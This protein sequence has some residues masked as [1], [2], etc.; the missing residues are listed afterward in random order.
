MKHAIIILA[1]KEFDHLFHLIEYFSRDCSVFVHIDRRA[2]ITKEEIEHIQSLSQVVGV[3]R[4]YKVHWGGFSILKCE[5]FMLREVLQH[6]DA[7]FVHLLSGQDYPVKPLSEFLSYFEAHPDENFI[8][9]IPLP[10]PRWEQYTYSRFQYFYPYDWVDDG[11]K[12]RKWVYKWV[13]FQKRHHIKRRIPDV[14]DRMYGNS[15]WFSITRVATEALVNYTRKHPA[16][17][18]R[19]RMTFAPE[20]SYIA[21]VL[22]N[23][24]PKARFSRWN[25]WFI[26]WR[27]QNGNN[28]ANLDTTHFHF[29]LERFYLFARKFEHPYGDGL[30]RLI[31]QY[32]I[33][34]EDPLVLLPTGGWKYDGMRRYHYDLDFSNALAEACRALSVTRMLDMGCGNGLYVANLRCHGINAAGY[35]ANPYTEKL[36]KILLPQDDEPCGVAD[37]TDELYIPDPFDLVLCKDVLQYIPTALQQKALQNL[38]KASSR[39]ILIVENP[40]T[41]ASVHPIDWQTSEG[42][43]ASFGF[44]SNS[45]SSYLFRTLN[46]CNHII[47][48]YSK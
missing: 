44:N 4:K 16:H 43:L 19:L 3:Y 34:E 11:K 13:S 46:N 35:D 9:H 25:H 2:T 20:E 41:E 12:A 6:N 36:S 33:K 7:N 10:N 45:F 26:Y 27:R 15:Q 14:F 39:H 42:I 28:P 47:K 21:T 8:Q 1:H 29:L 40:Q 22:L 38:A 24:M 37:L 5:L 31:D 30:V 23:I 48:L 18:N 32:L 17:Y